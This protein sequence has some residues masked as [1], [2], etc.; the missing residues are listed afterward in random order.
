MPEVCFKELI[1]CSS[2]GSPRSAG[3]SAGLG[4]P[5]G[6]SSPPPPPRWCHTARSGGVALVARLCRR[7]PWPGTEGTPPS[8]KAADGQGACP[9]W[10]PWL[11]GGLECEDDEVETVKLWSRCSSRCRY[12]ISCLLCFG[13]DD[14]KKKIKNGNNQWEL[15]NIQS[16]GFCLMRDDLRDPVIPTCSS[17]WNSAVKT[18]CVSECDGAVD[19]STTDVFFIYISASLL[20]SSFGHPSAHRALLPSYI[21]SDDT[22]SQ[23]PY[24]CTGIISQKLLAWELDG[25]VWEGERRQN[26][27]RQHICVDWEI[28]EK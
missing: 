25:N 16:W 28:A 12:L 24:Q 22:F 7:K 20:V 15:F 6:W 23:L 11:I 26:V 10:S 14:A 4:P 9:C 3:R 13:R 18:Q 27:R 19:F 2:S 17:L 8:P 21:L 5:P 1:W